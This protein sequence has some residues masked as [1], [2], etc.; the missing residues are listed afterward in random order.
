MLKTDRREGA[1]PRRLDFEGSDAVSSKGDTSTDAKRILQELS[2]MLESDVNEGT[3]TED[4]VQMIN[5]TAHTANVE[6]SFVG[7]FF[8][9]LHRERD[10]PLDMVMAM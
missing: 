2:V 10:V 7:D 8:L 5:K 6:V 1:Q 9:W 3:R 4:V